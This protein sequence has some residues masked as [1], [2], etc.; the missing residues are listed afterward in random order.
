MMY[1]IWESKMYWPFG[2]EQMIVDSIGVHEIWDETIVLNTHL[3]TPLNLLS[4]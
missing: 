1:K 4:A 2:M 3:A